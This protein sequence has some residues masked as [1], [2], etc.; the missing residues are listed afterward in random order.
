[1]LGGE[2]SIA[3]EVVPMEVAPRLEKLEPIGRA[4]GWLGSCVSSG[5][6]GDGEAGATGGLATSPIGRSVS[7]LG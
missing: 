6:V 4:A 3:G 1:M 5:N 7:A 2:S